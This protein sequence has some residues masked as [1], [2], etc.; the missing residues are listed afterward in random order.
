MTEVHAFI[1]IESQIR[2]GN[3]LMRSLI[4]Q[5][6]RSAMRLEPHGLSSPKPQ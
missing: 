1:A 3:T 4:G 6:S 5:R 2:S